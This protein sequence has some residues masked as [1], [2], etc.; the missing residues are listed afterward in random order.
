MYCLCYIAFMLPWN[1]SKSLY[2]DSG[3]AVDKQKCS[4]PQMGHF[5]R[6]PNVF[7]ISLYPAFCVRYLM[8][9]C[10]SWLLQK[11][12][13]THRQ[14]ISFKTKQKTPW[15]SST[16][17]NILRS[18]IYSYHWRV[19]ERCSASLLHW[20]FSQM[21]LICCCCWTWE[22]IDLFVPQVLWSRVLMF[23]MCVRLSN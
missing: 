6:N 19:L 12:P 3:K 8:K 14:P 5:W 18:S 20:R 16:F 2:E 13:L 9:S 7:L 17:L 21:C 10:S 15:E 4:H 23:L 11:V 22:M 1:R